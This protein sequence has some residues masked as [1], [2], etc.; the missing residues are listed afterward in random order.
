MRNLRGTTSAALERMLGFIFNMS[1]SSKTCLAAIFLAFITSLSVSGQPVGSPA[2]IN[3]QPVKSQEVADDGI[4]VII[5]HLPDWKNV[6]DHA[7]S[8]EHTSELQS[9]FG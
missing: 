9:R 8:E 3:G 7:R 4:P 5:K 2:Y 1:A 6:K